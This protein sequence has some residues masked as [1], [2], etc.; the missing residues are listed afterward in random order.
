MARPVLT[1]LF[2]IL[3]LAGSILSLCLGYGLFRWHRAGTLVSE[4]AD[5]RMKRSFLIGGFSL[6]IMAVIYGGEAVGVW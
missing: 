3:L 2:A 5:Q 4:G 6:L 1:L